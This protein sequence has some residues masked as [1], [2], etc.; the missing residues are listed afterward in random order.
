[1]KLFVTGVGGQLGHDVIKELS[2]RGH[3][4]VGSDIQSEYTGTQDCDEIRE[5]TYMTLDITDEQAVLDAITNVRP[6]AII[7][8]AGWTNVDKAED[9]DNQE[10]VKAVN[11]QGTLNIAKAARSVD[12][13]MLYISTDY[14]FDGRGDRPWH[15]DDKDYAPIN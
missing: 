5:M 8:C 6:D 1:M 15:P 4:S 9:K 14:V 12:A 3:Q 13:K 2:K 10:S 11:V 7:H